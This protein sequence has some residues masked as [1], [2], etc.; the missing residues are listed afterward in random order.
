MLYLSVRHAAHPRQS[1]S[2]SVRPNKSDQT[3]LCGL[4]SPEE[5]KNKINNVFHSSV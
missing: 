4:V 2:V 1:I 5:I 3:V